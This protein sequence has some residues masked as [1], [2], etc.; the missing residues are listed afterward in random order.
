MNLKNA[1]GDDIAS[2]VGKTIRRVLLKTFKKP[3]HSFVILE[4]E[5]TDGFYIQAV[6]AKAPV[7]EHG[8]RV[9]YHD[10]SSNKHFAA[11]SV[12]LEATIALFQQFNR[13]DEAF[14]KVI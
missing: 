11:N 12:P 13:G 4:D 10:P 2:P 14:R 3:G 7:E 5:A 9:E 8:C 6:P 1:Y